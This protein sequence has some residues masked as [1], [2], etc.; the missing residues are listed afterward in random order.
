MPSNLVVKSAAFAKLSAVV[1]AQEFWAPGIATYTDF[2][3]FMGLANHSP[4]SEAEV[5]V[6]AK[7]QSNALIQWGVAQ[8]KIAGKDDEAYTSEDVAG[9]RDAFNEELSSLK[10]AQEQISAAMPVRKNIA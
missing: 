8:D 4:V 3:T 5:I 7:A 2:Q 6:E 10:K 1:Q 9:L